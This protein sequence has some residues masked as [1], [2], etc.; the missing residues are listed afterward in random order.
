MQITDI[1]FTNVFILNV[2]T[3]G[4]CMCAALAHA[5]ALPI[6]TLCIDAC[7]LWREEKTAL[8]V[9]HFFSSLLSL[10]ARLFPK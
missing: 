8:C 5:H 10:F 1:N 3:L 7:I 6:V 9:A 2:S 4:T